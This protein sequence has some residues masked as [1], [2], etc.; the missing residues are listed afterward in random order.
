MK[1][2][3]F[4]IN[5]EKLDSNIQEFKFALQEIWPNS[6]MAY[7][8]KTNSIPWL[9]EYLRTQNILA[10]VVSDEEYQLA[11]MCGYKE[12]EMVFNSP[13]KGDAKFVDAIR[14]GSFV[15]IDSWHE[16]AAYK[17]NIDKHNGNVGVRANVDISMFN[18]E[19]VCYLDD[20]FRFG[21]SEKDDE[22]LNVINLVRGENNASIGLHV[23]CD[24]VT[25]SL[26]VYETLAEYIK[27]ITEK[28]NIN[29]SFVD[30][31]GGFFGG[32]KGKP[33]AREYITKIYEVLK[34]V[35][36]PGKTT[37][38]IEPGSAI[39]GSVVDFHTSVIDVKETDRSRIITTDGSR[40]NLDPIWV[41]KKYPYRLEVQNDEGTLVDKQIIC[42]YTSMNHD[43]IMILNDEKKLSLG[44]KVIYEKAGAYTVTFGGPFIKYFPEVYVDDGLNTTLVRKRIDVQSYYNIH[45][46]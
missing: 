31:G 36:D 21:F 26:N 22:L 16:V 28:Y 30:I 4:L 29:L 8:I 25:R 35:V 32:V 42:G 6:K 20:G 44:D 9:L 5:K 23:H 11:L 46:K 17:K 40:I 27:Y 14:K 18:N 13:I 10:E 45:S 3:Y 37:L 43:R 1:T 24:S 34:D 7:S 12:N 38:I 39:I 41:K 19:D 2:P 33:T 15:N